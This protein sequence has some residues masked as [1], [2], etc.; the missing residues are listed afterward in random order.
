MRHQTLLT[1]AIVA[2]AMAFA[3]ASGVAQPQ[4]DPRWYVV[5]VGGT[6]STE[7]TS[8]FFGASAGFIVAPHLQITG[9]VGRMHDV[10]PGFTSQDLSALDRN[11]NRGG[12]GMTLQSGVR[13][14]ANYVTAGVRVPL[15]I[16]KFARP[17][18]S[19]SAGVAHLSPSPTFKMMYGGTAQNITDEV[20][21]VERT[22]C[23]WQTSAACVTPALREETRPMAGIGAGVAFIVARHVTFDVGYRFSGIFISTDYLQDLQGS[24]DSHTRIDTH[25]FYAAAGFIF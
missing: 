4:D 14:P 3:P 23:A 11:V 7:V 13:V 10:L 19:A 5:G 15:F 24:P 18:A 20:L 21:N 22:G 1:S 17:Y 16:G 25:R 2:V 12:Y 6:T 9:D 8:P